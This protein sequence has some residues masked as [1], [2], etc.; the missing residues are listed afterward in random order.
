MNE[1][2]NRALGSM[3]RQAD[4]RSVVVKSTVLSLLGAASATGYFHYLVFAVSGGAVPS[5]RDPWVFM[6]VE[7]VLLALLLFLSALIGFSFSTRLDLPGFGKIRDFIYA[8]PALVAGGIAL[9]ALSYV[10]FDRYYFMVAP[11]TFPRE[12]IYLA[13]LPFKAALADETILRLGLVSIGVGLTKN[14]GAGVVLM[15][16]VSTLFTVKYLEFVGLPFMLDHFYVVYL[17]LSF[18]DNILLGWLFVTRGL[19]YS[20]ALKF[21]IGCKYLFILWLGG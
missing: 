16:A 7:L 6:A 17:L 18:F 5:G 14:K 19:L 15:S 2:W 21:V 10:V 9:V 4:L 1:L 12:T 13:A 20:M 8:L 3:T 11:A